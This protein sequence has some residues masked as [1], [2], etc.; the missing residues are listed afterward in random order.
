MCIQAQ[1]RESFNSAEWLR[2]A[3]RYE[4]AGSRQIC[5]H[6]WAALIPIASGRRRREHYLRWSCQSSLASPKCLLNHS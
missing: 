1:L 4:G 3:K 5:A 6:T 2:E